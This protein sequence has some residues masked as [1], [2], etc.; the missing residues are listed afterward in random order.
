MPK[1]GTEYELFVKDVYE[2]LNAVDGL[3]D[4]KIQHDIKLT[5]AAGVEHQIDVYWTFSK[6]GVNYRVAVECK[7]Y[8]RKVSKDR[9][10]SFH[11][12][13]HDIGNIYGI[14]VT[15]MG[16]QSGAI[17][18]AKKYG[19]QLMEIRHPI[20][21]DWKGRMRYLQLCLGLNYIDNV[22]PHIVVDKNRLASY[23]IVLSKSN[24]FGIHA[25]SNQVFIDYDKMESISCFDGLEKEPFV[26]NKAT[27][28]IYDLIT[29]LPRKEVGQGI[30]HLFRFINGRLR[31]LD[32]E[33]PIELP[34]SEVEFTYDVHLS[35]EILEINGDDY[36]KTIVKNLSDGTQKTIDR[37]G[38]IE[39]KYLN[40]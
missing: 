3:S 2:R 7:D 9:I 33:K 11:D 4:V 38:Q 31:Y 6:G 1:K 26:Y 28:S 14:F 13:L 30:K 29:I 32:E 21:D 25:K 19:I 17:E 40:P 15:K 10:Q 8:N 20:D 27:Q 23:G 35:R 24:E 39:T 12:V 37:F 34:I 16:F 18:Y 5:G 36:I 22:T